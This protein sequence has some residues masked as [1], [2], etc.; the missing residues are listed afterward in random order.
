VQWE[1]LPGD[2]G[3]MI[4][5]S[6]HDTGANERSFALWLSRTGATYYLNF[7]AD[8]GTGDNSDYVSL[9]KTLGGAPATDG[10]WY[11][12]RASLDTDN[13]TGKLFI[14][15][16]DV[17]A[18]V[19][20]ATGSGVA[21]NDSS[22]PFLVGAHMNGGTPANFLD[23]VIDAVVVAETYTAT[24]SEPL[25][26]TPGTDYLEDMKGLWNF[27]SSSY[28]DEIESSDLTAPNGATFVDGYPFQ[29]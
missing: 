14:D 16:S 22:A 3:A 17:S 9:T 19:D 25:N 26:V 21:I 29:L 12:Y 10:T 20:A 15:R 2:G 4:L 23:G 27:N 18:V 28:D 6:K 24:H 8:T 5:L 13:R 7:R 1:S 11:V